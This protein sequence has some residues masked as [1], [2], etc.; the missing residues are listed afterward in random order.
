MHRS[1]VLKYIIK[2]AAM[3]VIV[4]LLVT[5]II[6]IAIRLAPGDPIKNQLGPYGEASE[7]RIEAI[8]RQLGLDK[9]YVMQYLLWLKS[10][11][12][13][14]FGLSL[15]NGQPVIEVIMQKI[16]V[17]LELITVSLIFALLLAIPL[18]ILAAIKKDSVFDQLVSIFSTSFL[19]FPTFGV[20]L[21]LMIIFAVK[22][23]ILP[24]NGYIP[25]SENPAMNIKLLTMPALSLGLFEL[26]NF[27]RF[28]RSDT[29]EVI[30]SNYIRTAKAKGLPKSKVYFKHAFKNILVTL[31][32]VV[33]LE[34]GT[35]LGGTIIVEQLFGWSGLG[36]LI[37]QSVGNRDYPVV[38]TAVLFIAVAFVIINTI[39]DI[40]YAAIDPRIKLE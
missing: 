5:V 4:L 1:S 26:A 3:A 16:P 36:W 13:G 7:E 27:V 31:I 23:K 6:F 20:G 19:A 30:N 38:Q 9:S 34:F 15:R 10:C 33:G 29:L 40:L 2:R 21:I 32:T 37:Y 11:F 18:G 25:F 8:K 12:Q 35:L 22:L 28:I 14:N 39:I 17:S 24:A